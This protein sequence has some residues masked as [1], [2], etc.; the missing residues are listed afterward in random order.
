MLNRVNDVSADKATQ[1]TKPVSGN[2]QLELYIS[3]DNVLV[4]LGYENGRCVWFSKTETTDV[5]SSRRI[6]DS[7]RHEHFYRVVSPSDALA[8]VNLTFHDLSYYW[9]ASLANIETDAAALCSLSVV[10]EPIVSGTDFAQFVLELID[11]LSSRIAQIGAENDI[12]IDLRSD[13]DYVRS[14]CEKRTKVTQHTV[15]ICKKCI[16]NDCIKLCKRVSV[17]E[18]YYEL[19]SLLLSLRER[20]TT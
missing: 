13:C 15:E 11:N 10:H 14:I 12:L 1:L 7:L 19:W 4:V 20:R 2:R 8:T 3:H 9:H 5:L 18:S 16:R 6:F 17:R